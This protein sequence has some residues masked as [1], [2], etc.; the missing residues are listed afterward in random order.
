MDFF[1]LDK[2]EPPV[3][4]I[5]ETEEMIERATSDVQV[6]V[7]WQLNMDIVD[8]INSMTKFEERQEVA[9]LLRIRLKSKKWNSVL[10]ALHLMEAIAK[11]CGLDMLR[12]LGSESTMET[13]TKVVEESHSKRS[14]PGAKE[15]N[16]KAKELIQAW[17]EE[18]LPLAKN[19]GLRGFV[20]CY[21][22]LKAKGHEFPLPQL[23]ENRPP[24]FTPQAI[25]T[26]EQRAMSRSPK[27]APQQR[28]ATTDTSGNTA[29]SKSLPKSYTNVDALPKELHN[30]KY[31][32]DMLRDTTSQAASAADLKQNEAISELYS[33]VKGG[34][35]PLLQKIQEYQESPGRMEPLLNLNDELHEAL[36]FYKQ[37][38]HHGPPKASSPSQPPVSH[39]PDTRQQPPPK[40]NAPSQPSK[41]ESDI[42]GIVEET[43][44]QP[45]NVKSK[46]D[47]NGTNKAS[48]T[49]NK[50]HVN[51]PRKKQ[52][53]NKGKTSR[54]SSGRGTG[55][56]GLLPPPPGDSNAEA[57]SRAGTG[58]SVASSSMGAEEQKGGDI[59]ELADLFGGTADLSQPTHRSSQPTG[60]TSDPL[61]DLFG[62]EDTCKTNNH[63]EG[64]NY[65]PFAEIA[66]P[67]NQSRQAPTGQTQEFQRPSA[68]IGAVHPQ[69]QHGYA[70][71]M[72]PGMN[73]PTQR[74]S[75]PSASQGGYPNLG[76]P[77]SSH[78]QKGPVI[79][80]YHP[81]N[82]AQA[83]HQFP[84]TNPHSMPMSNNQSDTE[85]HRTKRNGNQDFNPF[86]EF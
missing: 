70:P 73:P 79:A 11:N 56:P 45:V 57:R 60:S 64:D 36:E 35:S 62:S 54:R 37:V 42:L 85:K 39:P 38:L 26:D 76:A 6:S 74:R 17:G 9:R 23:D 58:A 24:I 46:D 83:A 30:L 67:S 66:G 22:S 28:T 25:Q 21:H 3:A 47:K 13:M 41:A 51:V 18:F 34:E 15:V 78:P 7:D 27:E 49:M 20:E 53:E 71:S 61:N 31:S 63:G 5:G 33:T 59:D 19:H 2:L 4:D 16:L 10:L 86:D 72:Q 14:K 50:I 82:P 12:E 55:K 81:Y 68:G 52:G 77:R 32:I 80:P 48:Q 44:D 65:D 8:K 1:R 69:H 29:S 84:G 40:Q 75:P 43:F